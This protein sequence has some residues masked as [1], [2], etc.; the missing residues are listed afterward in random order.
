MTTITQNGYDFI[1]RT[2]RSGQAPVVENWGIERVAA[3]IFLVEFHR[4]RSQRCIRNFTFV[5]RYGSI[6][7][8]LENFDHATYRDVDKLTKI[9]LPYTD[10]KLCTIFYTSFEK[11]LDLGEHILKEK[12]SHVEEYYNALDDSTSET[13][14]YTRPTREEYE[15]IGKSVQEELKSNSSNSSS[16]PK[17]SDSKGKPIKV[18]FQAYGITPCVIVRETKSFYWVDGFVGEQ[19]VVEGVR[20]KKGTSRIIND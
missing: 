12:V 10:D 8:E 2:K 20:I 9:L 18:W 15:K 7:Y 5:S 19:Q 14:F 16:N 17:V 13:R 11:G 6:Q 1:Y 3:F 4:L